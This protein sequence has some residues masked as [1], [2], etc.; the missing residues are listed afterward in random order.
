MLPPTHEELIENAWPIMVQWL[1]PSA[2]K[3]RV[4]DWLAAVVE[5]ATFNE[6]TRAEIVSEEEIVKPSAVLA[7]YRSV[8]AG[9]VDTE[10]RRTLKKLHDEK[11]DVFMERMEKHEIAYRNSMCRKDKQ[12]AA[13]RAIVAKQ[14]AALGSAKAEDLGTEKALALAE[15]LLAQYHREKR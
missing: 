8:Y 4:K 3:V 5:T 14:M 11:L 1:R 13:V 10:Q 6:R 15:S 12:D 7:D 9:Q 2:D